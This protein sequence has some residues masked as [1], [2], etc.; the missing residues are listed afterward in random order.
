MTTD[1]AQ[2]MQEYFDRYSCQ[3]YEKGQ[4]LLFPGEASEWL[5]FLKNGVVKQYATSYRGDQIVVRIF[6]APMCFPL[7]PALTHLPNKYFFEAETVVEIY[8]AP[9]GEVLR[10]LRSNANVLY[11]LLT[12]IFFDMDSTLSRVLCLM[13]GTAK[14][15]LIYELLSEVRLYDWEDGKAVLRISEKDLASRAGLSRETINRQIQKLKQQ[16]LISVKRGRIVIPD[17]QKLSKCLEKEINL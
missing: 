3:R 13:T 5:Y 16:H 7:V 2:T 6:K 17:V 8:R 1:L 4:I 11:G 15:R 10:F 9:T 14:S 12:K